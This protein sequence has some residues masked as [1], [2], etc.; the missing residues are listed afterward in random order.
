MNLRL[1]EISRR[2]LVFAFGSSYF[3]ALV[4]CNYFFRHCE[5]YGHYFGWTF[6]H[7]LE[8]RVGKILD[9]HLGV[10]VVVACIVSAAHEAFP[11][12]PMHKLQ[13]LP[14]EGVMPWAAFPMRAFRPVCCHNSMDHPLKAVTWKFADLS[15]LST[16]QTKPRM[17]L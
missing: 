3:L 14:M 12:S 10:A 13:P 7:V 2:V 9:C 8:N 11:G 17:S 16:R 6:R 4:A 5:F 1:F 15:W